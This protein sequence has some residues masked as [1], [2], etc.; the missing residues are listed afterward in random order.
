MNDGGG[1]IKIDR[2]CIYIL[3]IKWSKLCEAHVIVIDC[4]VRTTDIIFIFINKQAF[5]F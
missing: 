3:R 2:P 4:E 5:Y 1:T